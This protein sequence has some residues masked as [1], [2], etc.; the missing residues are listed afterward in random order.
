[1]FSIKIIIDIIYILLL[2]DIKVLYEMIIF[3]SYI[4][5]SKINC[6]LFYS[7]LD[8]DNTLELM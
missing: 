3:K 2:S 4:V 5:F 7:V 8:R 6:Y 1:M